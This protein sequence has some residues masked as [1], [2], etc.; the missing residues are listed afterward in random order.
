MKFL[1]LTDTYK[2]IIIVNADAIVYARI[3]RR[4]DSI[5]L[6]GLDDHCSTMLEVRETPE[7]IFKIIQQMHKD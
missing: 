3:S 2:N 5:T 1:Q 7:V 6:V 4:D